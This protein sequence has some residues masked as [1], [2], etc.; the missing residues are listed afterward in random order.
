MSNTGFETSADPLAT[1]LMPIG[2]GQQPLVQ[3]PGFY[4]ETVALVVNYEIDH[5]AAQGLMPI[6]TGA[7]GKRYGVR[8]WRIIRPER[9]WGSNSL[10]RAPLA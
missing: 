5:D 1:Y 6:W 4:E 8:P 7:D 9:R 2:F 10:F 3:R